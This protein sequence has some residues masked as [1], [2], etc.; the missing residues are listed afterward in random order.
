MPS[1]AAYTPRLPSFPPRRSSDLR[2]A[3]RPQAA[4]R[5]GGARPA[6]DPRF[7]AL[8][9][10]RRPVRRAGPGTNVD[11]AG[12]R[13]PALRCR[14]GACGDRMRSEEHTSELQSLRHLVCRL[15]PR[16][17]LVYRPSLHDALPIFAMLAGRKLPPER[18]ARALRLIRDFEHCARLDDLF[19]ALALEQT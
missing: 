1:S 17:P 6:P 7:R 14:A 12:T 11:L 4:A 13:T 15:L 9:P 2:H 16:T 18:A 19:D 5:A 10:P 8:R 3:R